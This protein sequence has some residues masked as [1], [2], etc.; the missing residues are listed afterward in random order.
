MTVSQVYFT[1]TLVKG[2]NPSMKMPVEV[3]IEQ[4][5]WNTDGS[6][7]KA[8]CVVREVE[9]DGSFGPKRIVRNWQADK[10]IKQ[11]EKS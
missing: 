4:V 6:P 8:W 10:P 5:E 1:R 3:V 11:G 9:Y 7:N 2:H